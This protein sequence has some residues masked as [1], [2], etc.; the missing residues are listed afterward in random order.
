M[1]LIRAR[2]GKTQQKLL[3]VFNKE[4]QEC[5]VLLNKH[6]EGKTEKLKNPYLKDSLAYA[7]WVIARLSGWSGYESQR[8]PGPIDFLTGLQR[9]TERF[10]GFML[11]KMT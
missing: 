4:E 7:A 6:L 9:F 2:H 5:I 1:Q 10:E 8:P 3:S 11:A